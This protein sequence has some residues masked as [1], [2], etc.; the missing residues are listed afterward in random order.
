MMK[1]RLI[2]TLGALV[3]TVVVATADINHDGP[4]EEPDTAASLLWLP[5]F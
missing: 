3:L 4:S 5:L 1:R 2:A